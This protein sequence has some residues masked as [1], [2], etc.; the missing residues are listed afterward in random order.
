MSLQYLVCDRCM[1][2]MVQMSNKKNAIIMLLINMN[3]MQIAQIPKTRKEGKKIEDVPP[4]PF[5]GLLNNKD[6]IGWMAEGKEISH[7]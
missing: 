3:L 5:G 1:I 6:D 4:E 2:Y 7:V